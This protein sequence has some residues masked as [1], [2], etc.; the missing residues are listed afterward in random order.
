MD[1]LIIYRLL[2]YA[3]GQSCSP[4]GQLGQTLDASAPLL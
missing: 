3:T 1:D 4:N 2:I